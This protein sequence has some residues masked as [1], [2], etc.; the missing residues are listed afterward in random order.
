MK[1]E[2]ELLGQPFAGRG[3][4]MDEMIDVLRLL[5]SGEVVEH[6]GAAFDFDPLHMAPAP[7]E[8]VPIYIGGA[9]EVA[10]RR[11]AARGDG[12]IGLYH[13]LEELRGHCETLRR[14]REEAG[15]A[16]R[17]F[18]ILA[19][20]LAMPTPDVVEELEEMGVSAVATS[21]WFA[22]GFAQVGRSQAIDLVTSFGERYIAPLR[23]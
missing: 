10:F 13:T 17:P 16:D 11:A 23:A 2:F 1:E 14:Y 3:R 22:A 12:W 19:S 5:W 21:A 4:R 18:E 8:P 7:P 9:S 6:H 15:T 20:P